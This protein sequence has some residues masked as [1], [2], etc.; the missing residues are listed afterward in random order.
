MKTAEKP[1]KTAEKPR[2]SRDFSKVVSSRNGTLAVAAVSALLAGLVLMVFLERYRETTSGD[3]ST[4]TVLVAKRLIEQGSHGDVLASE[5]MFQRVTVPL[6]ELKDGA[7]TD[8]SSLKGRVAAADLYPGEQL[9]AARFQASSPRVLNKLGADERA[10]AVPVD[11]VH[12]NTRELRAGDRVDVL[13]GFEVDSDESSGPATG[14]SGEPVIRPLMRNVLVLTAPAGGGDG[15]GDGSQVVLRAPDYRAADLA[16]AA[17]HGK[18][19]L[20]IRPKAGA[21]DTEIPTVTQ[22]SV[23]RGSA[24]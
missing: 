20:L 8:P 23:L 5:G 6:G 10:I 14:G 3:A 1:R 2:Q 9:T 12:G 13:G 7:I 18:L 11:A 21:R 15:E 16:F 22:E 17:D 24:R 4:A 19:W